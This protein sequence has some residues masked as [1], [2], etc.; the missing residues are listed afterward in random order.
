LCN[1]KS[2][3]IRLTLTAIA[4]TPTATP[5]P[6]GDVTP[7]SPPFVPGPGET[8][9]T[10]RSD[11]LPTWV[12]LGTAGAAISIGWRLLVRRLRRPGRHRA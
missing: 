5:T 7:T 12:I 10:P 11:S 1:Q 3:D 2:C 9:D 4:E 6:A 8:G